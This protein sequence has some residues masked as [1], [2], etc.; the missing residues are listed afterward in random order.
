M[1]NI[2]ESDESVCSWCGESND[3]IGDCEQCGS[4][5]CSFCAATWD[6]QTR[7]CYACSDGGE[8]LYQ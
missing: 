1:N 5:M 4:E 7:K 8:D 3:A 2:F 6:C